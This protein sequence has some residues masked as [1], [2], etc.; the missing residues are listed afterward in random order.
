MTIN[1]E[2]WEDISNFGEKKTYFKFFFH[3]FFQLYPDLNK[4]NSEQ[5]MTIAWYLACDM[6]FFWILPIFLEA[7][8]YDTRLGLSMVT[9]IILFPCKKF[10]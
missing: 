1:F 8:K 6:Q 3:V 7:Y 5:C 10:C 9:M 2:K 4:P